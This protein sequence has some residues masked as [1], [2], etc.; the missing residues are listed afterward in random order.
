[1]TPEFLRAIQALAPMPSEVADGLTAGLR[2][3]GAE[4]RAMDLDELIG[5]LPTRWR[6]PAREVLATATVSRP[7]ISLDAVALAVQVASAM[8]DH[9]TKGQSVELVWS[10]P[11]VVQS[12]FRRTDRVWVEV[13]DAAE[14]DLWLAS[15]S[16]GAVDR[17]QRS[18]IAAL[19]RGVRVH[20]LFEAVADSGGRLSR[21]GFAS[22]DRRV[23]D[24]AA[25]YCWRA[26]KR[27]PS[28]AGHAGLMHAKAAVA[29]SELMFVTSANLTDAA[30]E[31]NLEVGVIVRGGSE[32]RRLTARFEA[33]VDMGIVERRCHS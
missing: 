1:M 10:G 14:S 24:R 15:F 9:V 4:V 3:L 18:L 28:A 7:P 23:L 33:L 21:D 30:L 2:R 29:D 25:V 17:V 12:T 13:I 20:L 27:E 19:D 5:A 32:P 11:N 8:L 6:D 22:F 16:V 26:D 31:R